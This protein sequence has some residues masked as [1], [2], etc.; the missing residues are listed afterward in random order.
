MIRISTPA[1]NGHAA[2]R[3]CVLLLWAFSL[4]TINT[5]GAAAQVRGYMIWGDV[6]VH[7]GR[8]EDLPGP[9]RLNLMLYN[10]AGRLVGRQT[11]TPHGRYRF[12]NLTAGEYDLAIEVENVEVTRIHFNVNGSP[13][14]DYRQD[15]QFEWK[16]RSSHA[17]SKPGTIS[18]ADAYSRS[19]V[20]DALFKKAEEAADKKK[21]DQAAAFLKQ[22]VE[23]DKLDFQAWTLLGT[24]YL[25]EEKAAD[26]EKAYLSAIEVNPTYTLALL[27]LGKLL[28]SQK[29]FDEAIEPL[30]RAVESQPQSQTANLL[31]GEAYIQ[32]RKGSKSIPYLNEAARLGRPEA[33]LRL[34]WLYNAAGMK[35]KAALEYEEFLKKMPD[36]AERKKLEE[37]IAANKKN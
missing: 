36:Y 25:L 28:S 10:R 33:H 1:K 2:F 14:A 32:I 15:L 26:A 7:V 13:G 27:D 23:N 19:S 24:V 8:A 21:Y 12:T 35:E 20:N 37:Y 11:V 17:R 4:A 16:S 9:T 29:K 6:N 18:A 22:I 30:T 31:L 5:E 34:G 3:L